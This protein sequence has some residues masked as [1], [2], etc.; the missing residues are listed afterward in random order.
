MNKEAEMHRLIGLVN[1]KPPSEVQALGILMANW[2]RT[3]MADAGTGVDQG[4]G[5]HEYDLWVQFGGKDLY[6]KIAE[7]GK[8]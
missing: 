4:A 8:A 1:D 2:L 5:F 7:S 3:E 6:I